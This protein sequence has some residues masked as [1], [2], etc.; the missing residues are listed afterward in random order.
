MIGR[1]EAF[2][3]SPTVLQAGVIG[4]GV[5][6]QHAAAYEAE[7]SANLAVLCDTSLAVSRSVGRQIPAARR[8]TNWREV[9][10]DPDVDAVSICTY[11]DQHAEQVLAAIGAGK[12]VFVEKPM[13]TTM[14]EARAIRATLN[15]N[16]HV[17]LSSNLPLR[18]SPRFRRIR[19][20]I[21]RSEFGE[22]YHI[23]A[24][25]FYG[26][27]HK[28]TDGW[29]GR[30]PNYSVVL[31]GA[32][33]MV[34]LV[35][36]LTGGHVEEVT[37]ISSNIASRRSGLSIH[38]HVVA[39]LR[40]ANGMTAKV[41]ANFG[42]VRPHEHGLSVFGTRAT[43]TPG[44]PSASMLFTSRDSSVPAVSI[45]DPHPGAGKGD[46]IGA[47][48]AAALGRGKPIVS[49]EEVFRTMCVCLAIDRS[50][51]EGRPAMVEYV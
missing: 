19:E 31:G 21:E 30:I 7:V 17:V 5:G 34:D 11:D 38:D 9:I 32:V 25:Y 51:R 42:C 20:M 4:L 47:F 16:S 3:S 12:H 10:E 23:E 27:L 8:T 35:L 29:R 33:H 13:C 6:A 24:D 40:C 1:E 37:A 43:L 22:L 44:S 14:E 39:L 49:V 2:S 28:L 41:S 26:R 50:A 48:V 18:L 46:Q 15:A 45:D 36:W